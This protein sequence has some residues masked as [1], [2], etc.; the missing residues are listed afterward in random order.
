MS[1]LS[2]YGNEWKNEDAMER[3]LESA[4]TE[5]EKVN[6]V[7]AEIRYHKHIHGTQTVMGREEEIF[8][9]LLRVGY[10]SYAKISNR[11]LHSHHVM[12]FLMR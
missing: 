10:S 11:S 12:N 7:Q 8:S 6:A 4:N 5:T 1:D 3:F 2:K 9:N